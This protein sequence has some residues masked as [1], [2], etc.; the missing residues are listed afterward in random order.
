MRIHSLDS[1]RGFAAI[2]VVLYHVFAFVPATQYLVEDHLRSVY[3]TPSFEIFILQFSPLNIFLRGHD[4]V[5]F[6]FVL[7]G[8]VLALPFYGSNPPSYVNFAL[9]RFC[10]LIVPAAGLLV[11]AIVLLLV[12]GPAHPAGYSYFFNNHWQEPL[13]IGM[14]LRHIFL[15]PDTSEFGAGIPFSLNTPLWTLAIEWQVGLLFPLLILCARRSPWLLLVASV[16]ALII[17]AAEQRV[18]STDHLKALRYVPCFALGLWLAR[19][20]RSIVERIHG[21]SA[22][23]HALLWGICIAL[24][25]SRALTP[26]IPTQTRHMLALSLGFTLL[27]ALVL[28]SP[29]LIAFLEARP[30]RW[31]G[32]VTFSLY[33][34][35]LPLMLAMPRILSEAVPPLAQMFIAMGLSMPLAG[36]LFHYVER[37]SMEL[38]RNLARIADQ[39]GP[40]L[41]LQRATAPLGGHARAS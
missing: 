31:L 12:L 41:G 29:R 2:S 5:I 28:A 15:I 25:H 36:L 11:F 21:M 23:T 6:F 26:P 19:Y 8:F 39:L 20:Y 14:L 7:S 38:G 3:T 4:W 9:R 18:I 40:R 1:L 32:K 35:H 22:G 30:L 27:I 17:S 16:G 24:C 10:R 34:C 37:P 13:S 33:L